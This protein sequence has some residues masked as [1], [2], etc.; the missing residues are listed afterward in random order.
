MSI[1]DNSYVMPSGNGFNIL[2]NFTKQIYADRGSYAY[3]IQR[4]MTGP[5][6]R[7]RCRCV[8]T[9]D[10][11]PLITEDI[12]RQQIDRENACHAK[13]RQMQCLVFQHQPLAEDAYYA[14]AAE[15][16]LAPSA[17]SWEET[18]FP[19]VVDLWVSSQEEGNNILQLVADNR[20]LIATMGNLMMDA[21]SDRQIISYPQPGTV[22]VRLMMSQGYVR[23]FFRG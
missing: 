21:L 1:S 5:E 11:V 14:I 19:H 12:I 8:N 10:D 18:L 20:Q 13:A 7:G 17:C 3:N 15:M 9:I 2:E 23:N 22:R 4:Y 16:G 6:W